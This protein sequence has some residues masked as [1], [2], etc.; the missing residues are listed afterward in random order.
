[1]SEPQPQPQPQ[2]FR[3]QLSDHLERSSDQNLK[4]A[5]ID[6]QVSWTSE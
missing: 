6:G 1:M 4:L 3:F 2:P 5:E